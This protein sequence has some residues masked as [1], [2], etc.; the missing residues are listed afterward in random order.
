MAANVNLEPEPLF[1]EDDDL[2]SANMKLPPNL[3]ICTS[4]GGNFI[5]K[6]VFER[7]IN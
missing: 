3:T 1:D 5:F 4:I 7:C 6:H 2:I